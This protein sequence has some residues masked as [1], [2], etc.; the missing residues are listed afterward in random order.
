MTHFTVYY[1]MICRPWLNQHGSCTT[2]IYMLNVHAVAGLTLTCGSMC[3]ACL[4]PAY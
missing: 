3:L 2:N 1:H 4:V